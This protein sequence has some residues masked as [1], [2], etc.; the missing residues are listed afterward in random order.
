MERINLK[1]MIESVLVDLTNNTSIEVFALKVQMIARMLKNDDFAFWTNNELSGYKK[2]CNL[3]DYRVLN[4]HVIAD[5]LIDNG[6]NATHFRRH[7]MP[8]YRLNDEDY[9]KIS[10]SNIYDS[11]IELEKMSSKD[12]IGLLITEYEKYVLGKIYLNST[13]LDASKP[14]NPVSLQHIVYQFKS[15]LLDT[16]MDINENLFNDEIDFDI[17]SRQPDIQKIV[18]Q[19]INAGI[20]NVGEGTIKVNQS[21]IGF[22][23]GVN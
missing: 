12:T 22:D 7:N 23:D 19:Y 2:S 6:F 11:V 8:L 16:F 18:N 4:T 13:I 17:M 1:S 3:P 10:T 9:K 5:L 14:I 21:N 15:K 20:V